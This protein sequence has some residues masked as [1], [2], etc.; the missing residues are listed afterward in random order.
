MQQLAGSSNGRTHPSGGWY[1]GSSPS[2]AAEECNDE[3]AGLGLEWGGGRGTETFPV[4]ENSEALET[5]G[6]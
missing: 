3:D 5:E 4:E 6:F 2:P 1:L